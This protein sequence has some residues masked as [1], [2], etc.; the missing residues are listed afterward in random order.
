VPRQM[1]GLVIAGLYHLWE[2]LAKEYLFNAQPARYAKPDRLTRLRR[3]TFDATIKEL[4][5]FDW[6]LQNAPFFGALN[7]ARLISNVI[8]HGPGNAAAKLMTVAPE[9]FHR[10]G[11]M[12][13]EN[14]ADADDLLL[15]PEHFKATVVAV[16]EFFL[17]MPK[18]L[19]RDRRGWGWD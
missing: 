2:Q 4:E 5:R 8:K 14:E 1:V 9:L 7:R 18:A 12:P 10:G 3:A 17:A 16:E 13:L 11:R 19:A 15:V 6:P